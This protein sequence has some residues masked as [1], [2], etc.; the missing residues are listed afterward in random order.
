M[1][2]ANCKEH[3]DAN[4]PDLPCWALR[5]DDLR[6]VTAQEMLDIVQPMT[7]LREVVEQLMF[8]ME[9]IKAHSN[10]DRYSQRL[11]T[12]DAILADLAEVKS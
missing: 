8:V 4:R 9:D 6:R 10:I 7:A 3:P 11:R 5:H 1:K 12:L 2:L